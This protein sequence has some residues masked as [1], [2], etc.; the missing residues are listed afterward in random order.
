MMLYIIY[1]GYRF[2][3]ELLWNT[4]FEAS[5]SST[6]CSKKNSC[7]HQCG[8][9]FREKLL[10]SIIILQFMAGTTCIDKQ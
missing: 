9:T 7:I 8:S 10:K 2:A 6:S 1:V 4:V 5:S 3:L